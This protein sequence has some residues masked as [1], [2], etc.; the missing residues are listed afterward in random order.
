VALDADT[1]VIG[2]PETTAATGTVYLF[3]RLGS[4]WALRTK[5]TAADKAPGDW[6]GRVVALSG[7][8]VL[9]GA[10]GTR[11]DMGTAY[12]F[13]GNGNTWLQQ[14]ELSADDGRPADYFG[15][16]VALANDTA[17]VGAWGKVGGSGAVYVFTRRGYR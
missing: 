12:L 7:N 8:T 15:V 6:F 4:R 14:A 5:L 1:A 16:S 9:V 3:V 11:N 13:R 10:W 2:A 17:L